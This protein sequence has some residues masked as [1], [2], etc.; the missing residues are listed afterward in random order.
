MVVADELADIAVDGEV[1][2]IR[3]ISRHI[4]TVHVIFQLLIDDCGPEGARL[5]AVVVTLV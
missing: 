4:C 5:V 1:P 3:A 2:V